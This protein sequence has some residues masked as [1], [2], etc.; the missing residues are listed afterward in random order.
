MHVRDVLLD[1]GGA[2]L[3]EYAL[4]LALLSAAAL[5][6]LIAFGDVATQALNNAGS[7][8]TAAGENVP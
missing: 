8:L 6:A 7:S 3:V 1:D 5:T 2:A 4:V